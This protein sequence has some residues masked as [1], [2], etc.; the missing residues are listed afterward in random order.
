MKSLL[1]IFLIYNILLYSVDLHFPLIKYFKQNIFI[2]VFATLCLL[3][4]HFFDF[5][6]N[7]FFFILTLIPFKKNRIVLLIMYNFIFITF[8]TFN[9]NNLLSILVFVPFTIFI[10]IIIR[11]LIKLVS[12]LLVFPK[13]LLLNEITNVRK[14]KLEDPVKYNEIKAYRNIHLVFLLF[15][16]LSV[17]FRFYNLFDNLFFYMVVLLFIFYLLTFHRSN[18]LIFKNAKFKKEDA[19]FTLLVTTFTTMIV[20]IGFSIYTVYMI[21]IYPTSSFLFILLFV[22]FTSLSMYYCIM[23]LNQNLLDTLSLPSILAILSIVGLLTTT[24][25]K[26]NLLKKPN[27]EDQNIYLISNSF[28][29]Y[30][31]F[32]NSV[33]IGTVA[34]NIIIRNKKNKKE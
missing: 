16:L 20:L 11:L 25:I 21:F 27:L 3:L 9:S 13:N 8:V 10:F 22:I 17:L 4:S 26:D 2:N 30:F 7:I 34:S 32:N 28:D 1:L 19:P 23:I 12:K 24:I 6:A 5:F 31:E 29:K 18:P 15:L 14:I 33:I